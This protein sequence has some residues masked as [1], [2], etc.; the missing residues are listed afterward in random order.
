MKSHLVTGFAAALAIAAALLMAAAPAFADTSEDER[1][2]EINKRNEALGYHWTAGKTSV[3][4]LSAEEKKQLLGLLPL[5]E[6]WGKDKQPLQAPAN[7]TFVSAYDWRQH[8]GVTPVTNQRSC[9]SCWAFAAVAQ[10]ESHTLIFDERLEDLSEQQVIDCNTWG[11]DCSGGWVPAACDL[12]MDPGCEGE[13]CYPYEARD[14]KPCRQ[15]Q[16][17]VLSKISD[18]TPVTNNVDAIKT[19]LQTG[20]V[21]TAF[22]VID[23]FYSYTSGCY[24]GTT[25]ANVNHAVLIIG[26]D[27]NQCSGQGAW[28]IKNSW[29][30]GWGMAGFGYVKYGSCNIGSYAYQ[31]T[32]L[33]T[34]VK[35]HVDSPNGGEIWNVG[36]TYNIAWDLARQ[37]PDSV[38]VVLSLDGG[39][40][41]DRPIAH[42]LPGTTISYDWTVPNL[43]V[44]TAR[45]KVIAYYENKVAGYDMSDA[46]FSIK[47]APYRYV[48]KSGGNVFPYSL[49]E[50]ASTT[51]Q[52]AVSAGVSGDTIVVAGDNYNQAITVT[53]PVYLYGGWNG[54]F[55]VRDPETYV[56]KIQAGGSLVTFMNI[57]AG[58]SGIEGFLLKSGSGTFL[59]MP[60]NGVYG[61]A[62]L[63]YQ[64]SPVIKNNR[65]DSCG[66]AS[67]LDFSGGGG[68]ACYGGTPLIEGNRFEGC[69]AQ[70]GGGIYLY[71]AAATIRN[72]RIAG[73]SPDPEFNGTKHGGGL[74]ALHSTVSLE[75]NV[76]ENND[77]Y[78]KGAGV[79]LYLS[80]ATIAGD[81]IALN[82]GLDAGAGI[83]ADRS[84][85]ALS[86]A[87]VRQNTS[88]ASGGAIYLHA[89]PVDISNCIVTMNRSNVIGGGMYADSCWGAITNNTFDRNRAGYGGGNT[90]LAAN[91][92]LVLE[93]NLFTYGTKNGFQTTSLANITFR[94][95]NCFGNTPVNI[96]APGADATNTSRHPH[97]ADTTSFDYHLLVNSGG[98]D[99]GDPAGVTDPDGSRADQGVFGGPEAVMAAPEYVKWLA[100]EG[101]PDSL[102]FYLVWDAV[103]GDVV[104][105]AVYSDTTAGFAPDEA[106]FLQSV[107]A[108][109]CSLLA[110]LPPRLR[111]YRVS[112]VNSAGLGGGYS[113]QAAVIDWHL[114]P[115]VTVV[116]PNGGEVFEPGDT[117]RVE[118]TATDADGVDS[119]SVYYSD[120]AGSSYALLAH[121]WPADS[122]YTWIL[123]PTLSDSCLVKVVAYDPGLLE[124]EDASDSLF[125]IRNTTGV[126]DT[127]D[128]DG[129]VVPGYVTA[130]EQ[131]YPN[132]FNGTTSIFYSIGER[133]DVEIKIFDPA[134]RV[135]TTL[136][137]A[138]REPGRYSVLWNGSDGAGRGVASGVYFCRIKAGKYSQTRKVLYLR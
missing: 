128:G 50:W 10:L 116:Y 74:Y 93:N 92:S 59:P 83:C 21:S 69:R 98:I 73:S 119:V 68:I 94:Y 9:G 32:Y 44:A 122:S 25:T 8:N 38:N 129:A 62:V 127:G 58:G 4:G 30:E 88:P 137:H 130:L 34:T 48:S 53:A 72:N 134:G 13:L 121:G 57:S 104:S 99:T 27:D 95:N 65:I 80:P 16:C 97:Y 67:V 109:A 66:V 39:A 78:R 113:E 14:D 111:Y 12:F 45:V 101:G 3:S 118:W 49:P 110:P 40:T 103:P 138:H 6:G 52:A 71:E 117:I 36:E 114:V 19:A 29:G 132:P 86:H 51:I 15:N 47:G 112:A 63:S 77:G 41:Y 60:T 54:T 81:T 107:F 2:A 133:C 22:T 102:S 31:I 115:T 79:Y 90:F 33:P 7:A 70:S 5:P 96:A 20:P 46:N 105:Y 35:V 106:N 56:T 82:D 136:E 28:I 76:I 55:T 123:P 125:A 26:W 135:I 124:G 42:G 87:V 131:N 17:P 37:T 11:A 75:G 85:L 23:D 91:P 61:G 1:I 89:S 24:Q 108:P 43:P 84:S 126:N 100:T 120:N 64:S 18:Y